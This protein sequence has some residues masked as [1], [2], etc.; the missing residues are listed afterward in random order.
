MLTVSIQTVS[1][2]NYLR[3]AGVRWFS[4]WIV[5][6]WLILVTII[7]VVDTMWPI[8][9][10]HVF[11]ALVS[12]GLVGIFEVIMKDMGNWPVPNHGRMLDGIPCA[13]F[14]WSSGH[15]FYI[16]MQA[17]QYRKS[18]CGDTTVA[19]PSYLYN[20]GS[21]TGK[22]ASLTWTIPL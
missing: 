11:C 1:L 4:L 6:H 13:H 9:Y 8:I 22:M 5:P 3:E 2:D 15:W 20:G 17:Y 7:F 10:K 18:H 12:F 19:R 14:V 16:T 21:Y